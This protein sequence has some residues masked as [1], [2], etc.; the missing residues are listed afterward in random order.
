MQKTDFA[1]S[2]PKNIPLYACEWKPDEP[3]RAVIVLI[4]G[5]GEHIGRYEHVAKMFTDNRY[6]VI[7]ADLVGHGKSS[8]QRGH[9]DS[10]DDFL[11]IIDWMLQEA[12]NRYPGLPRFIYGHSLGGNLGLYYTQKRDPQISGLIITSPGLQPTNVPPLKYALGK[13]LYAIYP[14]FKFTNSL[15][16]T[17]LSHDEAVLK[18]YIS[19][20][21]VHPY[22]SARLGL[23]LINTGKAIR[24]NCCD[25]KIP[26]LLLHGTD[27]RLVN[28]SGTS[29]FV[30][31]LTSDVQFVE[32]AG[33]YHELHNEPNKADIFRIWLAWLEKI[34]N[35]GS[36]SAR[37]D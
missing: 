18:A 24:E 11:D 7:A 2:T 1:W 35:N 37:P 5:I 30:R 13:I 33:G 19:D 36:A 29:E 10:Y 4:H 17:G 12:K 26:L 6:A 9:I 14:R 16:A 8:G 25:F 3:A 28:I 23:D 21:L 15:D 34:V 27:D 20:P 32:I 31:N 22:V